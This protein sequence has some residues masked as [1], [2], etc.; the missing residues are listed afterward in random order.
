MRIN[1]TDPTYYRYRG[2][3]REF[4]G[5]VC[6]YGWFPYILKLA[7]GDRLCLY[8]ESNAHVYCPGGRAVASRSRDGGRTWSPPTVLFYKQDWINHIGYGAVQDSADR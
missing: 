7:S 5:R 4:K 3:M 2:D 6:G 8:T 1:P